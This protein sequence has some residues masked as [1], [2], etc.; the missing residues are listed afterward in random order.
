M[1]SQQASQTE[2]P[3]PHDVINTESPDTNRAL[4]VAVQDRY[5]TP[6]AEGYSCREASAVSIEVDQH[7][8]G[9]QSGV[10]DFA[11]LGTCADYP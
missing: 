2:S 1:E 3:I 6:G 9:F 8:D 10:T 5:T 7:Q 4:A 11:E